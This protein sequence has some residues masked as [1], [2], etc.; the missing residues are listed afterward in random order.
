[1]DVTISSPKAAIRSGL[2]PVSHDAV[3]N[4]V[5]HLSGVFRAYRP[6]IESHIEIDGCTDHANRLEQIDTLTNFTAGLGLLQPDLSYRVTN[7]HND[8][9]LEHDLWI[10]AE[11]ESKRPLLLA[12]IP[13]DGQFA[14]LRYFRT[15]GKG[16]SHSLSRYLTTHA[17]VSEL[18]RR[19]VRWLLDTEPAGAQTNGLRHFQRMVG[20]RYV[21]IAL[22][23]TRHSQR[24]ADLALEESRRVSR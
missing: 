15:L 17:V 23:R 2:S 8:D 24:R 21:R 16:E 12:V 18:C 7:P 10:V 4:D 19:G 13:Y 1:M 11:D 5:D 6:V 3:Q 9:L 20:F 22:E 14:V